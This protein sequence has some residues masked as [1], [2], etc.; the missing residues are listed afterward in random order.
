MS[1]TQTSLPSDN[2]T[3][4]ITA[5]LNT[6]ASASDMG[7]E[8][9][10]LCRIN[11]LLR[12][13]VAKLRAELRASKQKQAVMEDALAEMRA[14]LP[15]MRDLLDRVWRVVPERKLSGDVKMKYG[16]LRGGDPFERQPGFRQPRVNITRG[17]RSRKGEG[18][19]EKRM[20]ATGEGNTG[21][22][23]HT[24]EG[25]AYDMED[26]EP[27]DGDDEGDEGDEHGNT[28]DAVNIAPSTDVQPHQAA[29]ADV[30]TAWKRKAVEQDG[31]VAKRIKS[32]N[33]FIIAGRA[34]VRSIA[35]LKRKRTIETV[36]TALEKQGV[37]KAEGKAAADDDV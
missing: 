15:P 9:Y 18:R 34:L 28:E 3:E 21:F 32:G 20:E 1:T 10:R 14:E 22:L 33:N 6:G 29:S 12:C 37:A 24:R 27:V 13:D 7:R 11:A 25:E 23:L 5:Q 26:V 4:R 8:A 2:D 31:N 16:A 36:N 35:G 17:L 19:G 30:V